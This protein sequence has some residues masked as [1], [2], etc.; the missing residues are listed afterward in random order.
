MRLRCDAADQSQYGPEIRPTQH[1]AELRSKTVQVLCPRQP[2]VCDPADL[3]WSCEVDDDCGPASQPTKFSNS[4]H[5]MRCVESEAY[6][7]PCAPVSCHK[8]RDQGGSSLL[9][10]TGLLVINHALRLRQR[11]ARLLQYL[12]RRG[13]LSWASRTVH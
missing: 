13:E 2:A 12:F 6:P 10:F 9:C 7:C 5:L 1:G 4:A 3:S 8:L 11:V